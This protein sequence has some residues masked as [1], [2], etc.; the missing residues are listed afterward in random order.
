MFEDTTFSAKAACE[1]LAKKLNDIDNL[2][3]DNYG[4][5]LDDAV[6]ELA[7]YRISVYTADQIAY[8]RENGASVR[9]ALWEG[10]A[11]EPKDFFNRHEGADYEEY[12][13][14]LG[15]AAAYIDNERAIREDLETVVQ[16]AVLSALADRYGDALDTEAA[17]SVL[18]E[19]SDIDTSESI[20]CITD[21]ACREYA[22]ALDDYAA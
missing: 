9:E 6:S 3:L 1:E 22:E 14:H 19:G 11:L 13:A 2:E 10:L 7:S 16:R 21:T 20:D 17:L 5:C 4:Y 12:E 15:V 18:P 8:C